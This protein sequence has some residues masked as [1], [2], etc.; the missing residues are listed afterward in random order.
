MLHKF[1]KL[2]AFC[3]AVAISQG[4]VAGLNVYPGPV[5]GTQVGAAA[6]AGYVGEYVCAQVWNGGSPSGCVTNS[7]TPVVLTANVAANITSITL[8][9]GDWDISGMI[10]IVPGGSTQVNNVIEGSSLTS[11]A[12][13]VFGTFTQ[14][15][16]GVT[17]TAATYTLPIPD[18]H[19]LV[20]TTT[21]V[22]LEISVGFNTS[23]CSAIGV[24]TARRRQ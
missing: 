6:T 23:T 16:P 5:L 22:Y 20:T 3:L 4:A 10:G 11:G 24:I 7:S 1:K 18:R 14:V 19:L 9:P 12:M 21:T 8:S 17:D 13:D 2:L 15:V